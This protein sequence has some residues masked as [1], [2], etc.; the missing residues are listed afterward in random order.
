[1]NE[2]QLLILQDWKLGPGRVRW[3]LR[4]KKPVS[5]SVW[6]GPGTPAKRLLSSSV[7]VRTEG[8]KEKIGG[9]DGHFVGKV[10]GGGSQQRAP[11]NL[12]GTRL[13]DA[14]SVIRLLKH[15]PQLQD[16]LGQVPEAKSPVS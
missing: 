3:Q 4:D 5:G 12:A 14:V 8:S 10:G 1:M 11:R 15:E 9:G 16:I 13:N 2:D 6:G 7:E